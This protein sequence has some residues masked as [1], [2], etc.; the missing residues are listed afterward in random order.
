MASRLSE[1]PREDSLR[2]RASTLYCEGEAPGRRRGM[3]AFSFALLCSWLALSAPLAAAEAPERVTEVEGIREYRL[4]N[5]LKL[6]L[7]PDPSVASVTVNITYLVGSR[8]E[9]GGEAGMAHLLEHMV[10][11]GTPTTPDVWD[12]LEDRGARFNG[13]T[14]TDRTNYYETL[15]ASEENLR[16]ALELEADRMV[17]SKISGDD[18]ETEMTVV[19]NEFES[20]E[21]NP[22]GILRQ[23]M[24]SQAFLWHSYGRSTIG[25]R[26]DIERVPVERLQ[27]FYRKYYQP[28]NAMLVISG[29]FD[30][31][32]ALDTVQRTFGKL[33]R[34]ERVLEEP[35]TVEPPQDGARSVVLRRVGTVA[36]AGLLYHVPAGSH[37]DAAALDVLAEVLDGEP[38]GLLYRSLVETQKASRLYANLYS[39]HDPGVFILQAEVAGGQD[40]EALQRLM[41]EGVEQAAGRITAEAVELARN[42]LLKDYRLALADSRRIA[43]A[44]SDAEAQGD[45]R[46]LFLQRD[47]LEKVSK[48]DVERVAE[49]YLVAANRTAGLFL[50]SEAATRVAIPAAPEPTKL[51][52]GYVGQKQIAQGEVFQ[53]TAENIEQKTQRVKVEGIE[54]ALLPKATR[55]SLVRANLRFGY[56]SAKALAPHTTALELLPALM[57]RGTRGKD[58]AAIRAE[59]DRLQAELRFSGEAGVVQVS[60]QTPRENLE[61]SLSLMVEILRQPSLPADQLEILR[62]ERLASIDR[63]RSDPQGVLFDELY[64]SLQPYPKSSIHYRPTFDEQIA[65]LKK[66]DRKQLQKLYERFLG[67]DQL[68]AALVGDFDTTEVIRFFEERLAGWAAKEP[69]ERIEMEFL[70]IEAVD[71]TLDTPDKEMTVVARATSFP[72]QDTDPDY[73]ALRFA[74][75]V[76]GQ[77]PSSRLLTELRQNR[78]LSYGAGSFVRASAEDP[79]AQLAAYAICAPQN[80]REAQ[81]VIRDE[82]SRFIAKPISDE[83]LAGFRDGYLERFRNQLADDSSLARQLLENL[84]LDRPFTYY[85]KLVDQGIELSGDQI[86]A[87]LERQLGSA[88]FVDFKAGDS[89]K[90]DAP[91]TAPATDGAD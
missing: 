91:A 86:Q 4:A 60:L 81:E 66:V 3:L 88:K 48:Q 14:W 44:L 54:L 19:R 67:A 85:R 42:K 30:E 43:I 23:R 63:V 2:S 25:N 9:G 35:Y 80:A 64:R 90:F 22:L 33:P 69:Y 72:M 59:L 11:K 28:D 16:F 79:V 12:A 1:I 73:P 15:P 61:A 50:P 89:S 13:T 78:G 32:F 41:I 51:L 62:N 46:L 56:G 84:H 70:P 18:L 10:F 77:S 26:S 57:Q 21:N 87:A 76:F 6:L 53:A 47:Q 82:F 68:E 75:Y 55:G 39:W 58:Y 52:A 24:L 71:R 7:F 45:W 5:G 31:K 34:P 8:H 27:S 74:N 20:G 17:N 83:E 40:P 36:S 49:S 38:S 65:R 29:R 37:P